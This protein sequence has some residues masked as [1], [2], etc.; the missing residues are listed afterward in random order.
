MTP[1]ASEQESARP[2]I[3]YLNLT[4]AQMIAPG[5]GL[6]EKAATLNLWRCPARLMHGIL[7]AA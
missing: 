3:P 7:G 2:V 1:R 5:E 4:W 6:R